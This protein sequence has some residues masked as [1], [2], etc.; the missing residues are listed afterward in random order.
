M[1]TELGKLSNMKALG[2][3]DCKLSGTIPNEIGLLGNL[4]K[5]DLG[6]HPLN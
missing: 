5:L 4:L 6:K 3:G 2:L 1:P